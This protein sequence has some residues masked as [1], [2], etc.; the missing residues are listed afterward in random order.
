MYM[1]MDGC[2]VWTVIFMDVPPC[3]S[4]GVF[5][6][7]TYTRLRF[8]GPYPRLRFINKRQPFLVRRTCVKNQPGEAVARVQT[9][10]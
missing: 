9:R 6:P 5:L 10:G 1:C 7:V 3:V 4:P 8:W 2:E